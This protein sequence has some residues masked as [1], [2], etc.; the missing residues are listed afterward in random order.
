V[1]DRVDHLLVPHEPRSAV[2]REILVVALGGNALARRGE[3]D[4]PATER[5]RARS[6]ADALAP[7]AERYRLVVTHGNGPQVGALAELTERSGHHLG[8]DVLDAESEGMIG[9]LLEQ[10]LVSALP[11]RDVA[12]VLTQVMVDVD[13]PA[14][15]HPT[16]PV[17]PVRTRADADRMAVERGWFVARDGTGWRRVVAS[18]EPRLVVGFRAIE[19]LVAHDVVVVAA[20][21]G[22]IPVV[23]DASGELHGVDAVIDKDLTASLLACSLGASGL[24]LLTDVDAVADGWGTASPRR[25]RYLPIDVARSMSWDAGSMGPKIT[26]CCRFVEET[27]GFAVIGALDDVTGVIGATSGTRIVAEG[28]AVYWDDPGDLVSSVAPRTAPR[29]RP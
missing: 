19:L 21:G 24:V 5:R 4:D 20:G 13:D 1:T 14:F 18:P 15:G 17:G 6:A 23:T 25:V 26:A 2:K 9:Y 27:G 7:L 22:G 29:P 8:L 10:A 12:T 3:P 28:P 16:K 11:G